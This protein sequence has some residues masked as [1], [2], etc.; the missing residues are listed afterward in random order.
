MTALSPFQY[1]GRE[2]WAALRSNAPLSL[3]D[4]DLETLRGLHED[5]SL[6]EVAAMY[7]PL[8]RLLNLRVKAARDLS[9]AQNDL[10]G[11]PAIPTP[12]VIAICGSVAVGKSTFARVLQAL[13]ARW[14]DQP[15]VALVTTDGFL[16]PNA[17]LE[18]KDLMRRKG[19][20]ESYDLRRLMKFLHA[21]K[22]DANEIEAHVY[23]HLTYDIA[24]GERQMVRRPDILIFEGINVLQAPHGATVLASDFF[25]FSVY[26]DAD[27]SDIEQWYIE[28]FLILQCTAFQNPLSYFYRYRELPRGEAERLALSIWQEINL[29]NLR[30]NIQPTRQRADLILRKQSDHSIKDVWLRQ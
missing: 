9:R 11:M 19:F 10:L 5:L 24:A 13:L 30:E 8:S 18:Q 16:Y 1:F 29:P 2:E 23:S 21:V 25:D 7:L 6:T 12:F 17:V 27:E 22:T 4:Q 28:R 14:P 15:S 3:S 26:I 20:P